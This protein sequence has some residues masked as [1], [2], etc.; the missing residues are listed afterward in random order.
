LVLSGTNT[1]SGPTIFLA[2][3]IAASSSA[4]LGNGSAT[5]GMIFD[6]GT[7][8]ALA[9][10]SIPGRTVTVN[11]GNGGVDTNGFDVVLG[12]VQG[13]GDF[14]KHPSASSLTVNHLRLGRLEV[15]GGTLVIAP[16]GQAAG[17][18]VVNFTA[19]PGS[20]PVPG[21]L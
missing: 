5:N 1:F 3:Y 15:D 4:K 16:N 7:L 12:N 19:T 14:Y 18:C 2:G 21:A 9:N 13:V 8:K 6:G 17:V 11:A 10:L 20:L